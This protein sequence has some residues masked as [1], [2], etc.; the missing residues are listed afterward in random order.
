MQIAC[1]KSAHIHMMKIW[2]VNSDFFKGDP[3]IPRPLLMS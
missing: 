1:G 3:G 2:I